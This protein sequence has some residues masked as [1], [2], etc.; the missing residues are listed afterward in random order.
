LKNLSKINDEDDRVTLHDLIEDMGKGIDRQKSPKESGEAQENM[1]T[2]R[3]NSS[4]KR[5]FSES[6]S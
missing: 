3:Y 6:G 5:Q 2:K 4:S 1:V